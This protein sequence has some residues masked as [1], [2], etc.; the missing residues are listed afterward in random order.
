MFEGSGKKS[1]QWSFPGSSVL[2]LLALV[3]GIFPAA[4]ADAIW[5][6]KYDD[7]LA[8]AR[9]EGKVVIAL[10]GSA[11]RSFRPVAEIF[12]QKFGFK[13]ILSTGSGSAQVDRVLAEQR[14]G[15]WAV[16]VLMVGANS[17]VRFVKGDR[18]AE[19]KDSLFLPEILDQ[20]KWYRGQ[21]WYA[22]YP[23]NRYMLTYAAESTPPYINFVYNT[24]QVDVREFNSVW[25]IFNPK[26]KGKIVTTPP[27]MAGQGETWPMAYVHPDIGPEWVKRFMTEMDL[28]FTEDMR[29]AFDGIAQGRWALGAFMSSSQDVPPMAKDGLPIAL[30]EDTAKP[31]KEAPVL[32]GAGAEANL[33]IPKT[34]PNPNAAKVFLN[35]YLSLEGQQTMM[36]YSQ[37]GVASLREDITDWGRLP[38]HQLRKPGVNYLFVTHDPTF[39]KNRDEAM[40]F[41][42]D[43]YRKVTN[44]R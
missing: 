1:R 28:F 24:K 35:W 15:T 37:T 34:Q 20:S 11:S 7:L 40:T 33:M 6:G 14:A 18:L 16:D 23:E 17:G 8:A 43:T 3:A 41:L 22:D 31:L 36:K 2:L 13:P 42:V 19:V 10:G 26:W 29:T 27:T 21:H 9:K 5:G 30:L 39:L 38:A 44:Q 12:E 25:D 4:A 32:R